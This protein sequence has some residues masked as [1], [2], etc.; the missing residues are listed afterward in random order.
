MNTKVRKATFSEDHH[1][2]EECVSA[3]ICTNSSSRQCTDKSFLIPQDTHKKQFCYFFPALSSSVYIGKMHISIKNRFTFYFFKHR[4][5]ARIIFNLTVESITVNR[6][7]NGFNF[8]FS[9]QQL[10]IL[11]CKEESFCKILNFYKGKKWQNNNNICL[12][13]RNIDM[14]LLQQNWFVL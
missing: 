2:G 12:L 1:Y 3:Q 5:C 9:F 13:S 10:T 11:T 14:V 7:K 4:Y 8:F 6:H